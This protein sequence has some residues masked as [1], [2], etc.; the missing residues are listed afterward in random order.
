M[1]FRVRGRGCPRGVH[2]CVE[3]IEDAV[4]RRGRINNASRMV[5]RVIA[6]RNPGAGLG[7][8]GLGPRQEPARNNFV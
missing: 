3:L 8:V 6:D 7:F 2:L 5:E 1:A 4:G